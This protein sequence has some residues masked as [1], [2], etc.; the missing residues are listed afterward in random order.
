VCATPSYKQLRNGGRGETMKCIHHTN[1]DAVA[2][3]C[4]C[5]QALCPDCIRL[6]LDR[7]T[8]CSQDCADRRAGRAAVQ[9]A[10]LAEIAVKVRGYRCLVFLFRLVGGVCMLFALGIGFTE[11][12]EAPLNRFPRSVTITFT[13]V[14][15][16]LS[17]V[18]AIG[19]RGLGRQIQETQR[20][21]S[22]C[23][24]RRTADDQARW[25]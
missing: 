4:G 3:C 14:L 7:E 13:A 10:L 1:K 15:V 21:L 5:G 24:Q 20:L 19:A 9:S 8:V 11:F 23:Q 25:E 16:G 2:I 17:M 22:G 12:W 18:C 6:T